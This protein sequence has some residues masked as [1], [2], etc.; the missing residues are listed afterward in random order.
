MLLEYTQYSNFGNIIFTVNTIYARPLNN[1][2]TISAIVGHAFLSV[3]VGVP[4]PGNNSQSIEYELHS[5]LIS[6]YLYSSKNKFNLE[7]QLF[8]C[9]ELKRDFDIMKLANIHDQSCS[10]AFECRDGCGRWIMCN[11]TVWFVWKIEFWWKGKW[12]G[13]RYKTGIG[14]VNRM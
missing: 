10:C 8:N 13:V 5:P 14:K 3:F 7:I 11:K 1:Q 4:W 9:H 2:W 12:R 6:W